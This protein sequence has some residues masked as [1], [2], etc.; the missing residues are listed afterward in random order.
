[1]NNPVPQWIDFQLWYPQEILPG[2]EAMTVPVQAGEPGVQPLYLLLGEP[3]LP[4]DQS[5]LI[6]SQLEAGPGVSHLLGWREEEERPLSRLSAGMQWL[7]VTAA[8]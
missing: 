7:T 5:N 8:D 1:M 4:R 6:R 3:C 2:K